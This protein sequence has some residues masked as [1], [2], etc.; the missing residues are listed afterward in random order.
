MF[1]IGVGAG[2]GAG[3]L[4][5]VKHLFCEVTQDAAH[6]QRPLVSSV[7]LVSTGK[8]RGSGVRLG[9]QQTPEN[10]LFRPR[11]RRMPVSK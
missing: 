1:W 2:G 11:R 4:L 6:G 8:Q 9:G 7:V 10:R 3:L 5:R